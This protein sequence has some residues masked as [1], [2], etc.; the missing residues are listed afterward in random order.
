MN[1]KVPESSNTKFI[2]IEIEQQ[3]AYLLFWII[4]SHN[5]DP[6]NINIMKKNL[7]LSSLILSGSM[8]LNAQINFSRPAVA[9]PNMNN[10]QQSGTETRPVAAQSEKSVVCN[11]QVTYTQDGITAVDEVQIGGV[12]GWKVVSFSS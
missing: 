3:F 1:I 9:Q 8:A 10:L 5:F 12:E 11:D 7:L 6:S 4:Y 2:L